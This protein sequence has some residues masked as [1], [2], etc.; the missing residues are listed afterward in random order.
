MHFITWIWKIFVLYI[1]RMQAK[2]IKFIS[3]NYIHT[4]IVFIIR[5]RNKIIDHYSAYI[6]LI[7]CFFGDLLLW[8][9]LLQFY[10]KLTYKKRKLIDWLID[11]S[12]CFILSNNNPNEYASIFD[13][14]QDWKKKIKISF[15][16]EFDSILRLLRDK[17]S[18]SYQSLRN[19][20]MNEWFN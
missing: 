5:E 20:W 16:V 4:N 18:I 17:Q 15:W 7:F 14:E 12:L 6:W 11:W 1:K 9:Y 8:T 10:Q 13:I 3:L 19:V 2:T